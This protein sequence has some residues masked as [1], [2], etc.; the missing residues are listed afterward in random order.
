MQ[1]LQAACHAAQKLPLGWRLLT[2]VTS[3]S[4]YS[5]NFPDGPAGLTL[6]K[7]WSIEIKDCAVC[8]CCL[9]RIGQPTLSAPAGCSKP[10]C[11]VQRPA[12]DWHPCADAAPCLP[13]G[14]LVSEPSCVNPLLQDL[15]RRNLVIKHFADIPM[16]DAEM[17][18]PDKRV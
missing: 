14:L 17:I 7:L 1:N 6:S 8:C 18:F 9:A 5:H 16:A 12:G 11:H 13:C 3:L 4:D 15:A 10:C 2:P